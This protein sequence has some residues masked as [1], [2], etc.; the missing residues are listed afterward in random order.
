MFFQNHAPGPFRFLKIVIVV[1]QVEEVR[2]VRHVNRVQPVVLESTRPTLQTCKMTGAK[3]ASSSAV[4]VVG[5]LLLYLQ[6]PVFE[7]WKSAEKKIQHKTKMY[8]CV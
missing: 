5:G 6:W 4:M 2:F 7:N 1:V 8:N 3:P